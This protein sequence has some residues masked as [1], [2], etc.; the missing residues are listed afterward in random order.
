MIRV[1]WLASKAE[2]QQFSRRDAAGALRE[3]RCAKQ[4]TQLEA[5]L[6]QVRDPEEENRGAEPFIER[7]LREMSRKQ[8]VSTP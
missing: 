7:Q 8:G 5:E 4:A 6:R 3:Y 1:Q 2:A